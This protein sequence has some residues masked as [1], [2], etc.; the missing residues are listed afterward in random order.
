MRRSIIL[1]VVL[2][3]CAWGMALGH[4]AS[5]I[6]YY[7]PQYPPDGPG[8]TIDAMFDDWG[9]YPDETKITVDQL[10]VHAGDDMD[11]DPLDFDA[12]I[13]WCWHDD[14]N[15]V[16]IAAQQFDDIYNA[17]PEKGNTE[18]YMWDDMEMTTD[19]DNSGGRYQYGDMPE[20]EWGTLGQQWGFGPSPEPYHVIMRIAGGT[21]MLEPPYSEYWAI[22]QEEATGTRI[23]H[24]LYMVLWDYLSPEGADQSQAHEL[25]EGDTVGM[26]FYF[27]D[28]DE[29]PSRL[30]GQWKTHERP[31][32]PHNADAAPD[33]H[34]IGPQ[35]WELVTAAEPSSWGAVKATFA[36]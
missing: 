23:Y 1:A 9:G 2:V 6:E 19:G 34:M 13:M 21:W 8:I 18:T 14:L 16:F 35:A 28:Y 12:T 25:Y 22:V 36:R 30:G 7:C 20:D 17:I 29:D 3:L 33:V 31:D 15:V 27:D 4:P 10:Y 24:E 5:G 11:L 32:L 26:S